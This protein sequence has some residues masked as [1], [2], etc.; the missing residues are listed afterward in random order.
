[1]LRRLYKILSLIILFS[2]SISSVPNWD[3]DEDGVLDNLNDFQNNGSITS[4]VLDASGSN[5]GSPGDLLASFVNGEQRGIAG[6]TQIPFGP[7][8]GQYSFLMLSYSNAASGEIMSFKFYDNELDI[9]YDL[10]ETYEFVSDMTEG[11][12]VSPDVLTVSEA[13]FD[14]CL[15]CDGNDCASVACDDVD[16]DDIC[17]DEDDCVGSYDA[18]GVCN[19]DDSSCA[20][21]AGIPSGMS[22]IDNCGQCV[23][24]GLECV[25][26]C[27]G[28]WGGLALE[29]ECG[30][31][32][33]NGIADG[34]CDCDGNI[35]DDCG[36]C[37]GDGSTC[38]CDL[39]Y[40]LNPL[41]SE[42][43]LSYNQCIPE[44][45]VFYNSTNF[46]GVVFYEVT[47]D[48]ILLESDDWVGAFNN[49]VCVG[50]KKW[51]VNNCGNGICSINL[52]GS[53][54][55][56]LTDGYLEDGEVPTF[57]IFDA[58]TSNYIDAT[59][60]ENIYYSYLMSPVLDSLEGCTFLDECGV[61][62]GLGSIYE[63]GC[64]NIP[65]GECDC[66][67]NILDC[68]NVCGGGAIDLDNDD[69]CDDVDDCLGEYDECGVCNGNGVPDG[70]CDCN[71]NIEDCSGECGGSAVLDE[72]GVCN[73]GGIPSGQCDC[74]GSVIDCLGVC[75]GTAN[76]DCLGVCDGNATVDICGEC[77]GN[78]DS[79]QQLEGHLNQETGWN[80][81]QSTEISFYGFQS[82]LIDESTA[83]GDG[84][85]PSSNT[86]PG[87]STCLDN[88]FTCDVV[89]AFL[90]GVCVGWVYA[91]SDGQTTVP[92]MGLDTSSYAST[93]Q[94]QSYCTTEDTPTFL[95]YSSQDQQTYLLESSVD[96]DLWQSNEFYVYDL[97]FNSDASYGCTNSNAD[98]YN[99][100]A[101][102]DDGTCEFSQT[103]NFNEGWNWVSFNIVPE[104]PALIDILSPIQ[105]NLS[106]AVNESGYA[107]FQNQINNE[108]VDNIGS[109]YPSE[110]YLIK[111]NSSD[112]LEI[113]GFNQILTPYTIDLTSGWNII[114]YPIQ[115]TNGNDVENVLGELLDDEL[116]YTM[117]DENGQVYIPDY[118]TGGSAQNSIG[119]LY[120]GKAY[121]LK[122]VD[123]A[124][125][126]ILEP[127]NIMYS[128]NFSNEVFSY[129]RTNHFIPVW[130]GGTLNPMTILLDVAN[131]D[132]M[133]L[134]QGDEVGI[135]DG[136]VCVG[137]YQVPEGG[138]ANY[139]GIEIS[140]SM[141]DQNEGIDGFVNGN[142]L[143]VRVWRNS[144]QIDIDATIDSFLSIDNE[145]ID[146]V[147]EGLTTPR[148]QI[149]VY[150]PSSIANVITNASIE[151]VSLSWPRPL[152]GDYK[153][154][155]N[156]ESYNSITF[157]IK[158][159]QNIIYTNLEENSFIDSNIDY[160]TFYSYQIVA[161]SSALLPE[162]IS[163]EYVEL[164]RPGT[165]NLSLLASSNSIQ[166]SWD[167]PQNSGDI[168]EIDY[169]LNKS[170]IVESESYSQFFTGISELSFLDNNL[171]NS[172]DYTYR[173]RSFN[174]SGGSNWSD[175]FT[176]QT[177]SFNVE[178]A[179]IDN[180]SYNVSQTIFPP[181]NVV[182]LSW[183]EVEGADY[184]RVYNQN[185]LLEDDII[186]PNFVHDNLENSTLY[187]YSITSVNFNGESEASD[188]I[189][190]M[191]F[192]EIAPGQPQNLIASS[193][194]NAI[195][196]DW[197]ALSGY[198]EPIGGSPAI[199]N[200]YRSPI[201][202]YDIESLES[203]VQVGSTSSNSY[204]DLNLEDNTYFCYSVSGVNSEGLE[205]ELSLVACNITDSQLAVS[206][207]SIDADVSG[208][209]VVI[210]WNEV[211][212]SP[213]IFY[214]VFKQVLDVLGNPVFDELLGVTELL[215]FTDSNL[216]FSSSQNYYVTASNEL[217]IS[218]PSN[219]VY[220]SIE[221]QNSRL[222][223]Y[224]PANLSNNFVD[225]GT[226]FLDGYAQLN[227]SSAQFTQQ[228]A[229]QLFSLSYSNNP[230]SPMAIIIEEAI[231]NGTSIPDGSIIAVFD[232]ELCVGRGVTP[233]P[234]GQIVVSSDDGE[235]NGFT[236]GN[237]V[238]FQV[239]N[240]VSGNIITAYESSFVDGVSTDQE[241]VFSQLGIET[242]SLDVRDDMY[243][244][245]RNG[246]LYA[247]DLTAN[248]FQDSQLES[249]M[250]YF[251]RVSAFNEVQN[252]E[253]NLSFQDN[254]QTISGSAPEFDI[255]FLSFLSIEDNVS[256]Q[257]DQ[258]FEISLD[259]VASD[260]D[261]DL[262]SFFALPTDP[263]YPVS[264][265][266]N[267]NVLS[268]V[269]APN[270][271][272]IFNISLIVFDD[273][274]SN[275]YESNTLSSQ[276]NFDLNVESVNDSPSI[277]N[278]LP[279]L[280]FLDPLTTVTYEIDLS[281]YIVDVD[282]FISNDDFI[283]Y[284]VTISND[285]VVDVEIESNILKID[286]IG[287][288]ET[289]ISILASDQY[290]QYVSDQFLV[291]TEG[292]LSV[293]EI[294]S[295]FKLGNVY[296]NP[297]NPIAYFKVQIPTFTYLNIDI[298]NLL[299]QKVDQIYNGTINS[300]NHIMS[301]EPV[302]MPS[303]MYFLKM[304]ADNFT[305]SN[306]MILL[307]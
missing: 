300:G 31:C 36:V 294:P 100:E 258:V 133:P 253:S 132:N 163:N 293:D 241:I 198:G 195:I 284:E 125:L 118:V 222:S 216:G 2:F 88:P 57:K 117:F 202:A 264:C 104:D 184:Y 12:V 16:E 106:L 200:I 13:S 219:V 257:E 302:G 265:S 92:V 263:S 301:W 17:D 281:E 235:G 210:S 276:I 252:S 89:G 298:Y 11:N 260:V 160:N 185:I 178:L 187:Q 90:N 44:N 14:P 76:L 181:D 305:A 159:D 162:S 182:E 179:K 15:D 278:S 73:G 164:T 68:A 145:S 82:I 271:N 249:G 42:G 151:S 39:G 110:G 60:S 280:N 166:L 58:S 217:G 177:L 183:N 148:M 168:A 152:L 41:W 175:Y 134:E 111:M 218:L 221:N 8:A 139:S 193:S 149:N 186:E 227:W 147:F 287:I 29:D 19:G 170:W 1:M 74:S 306:K 27:A 32:D 214:Q 238:Y 233:L 299:G 237:S 10:V 105:D 83:I 240:S 54:G 129:N 71:G 103:I 236:A 146:T 270:Y 136:D 66:D 204:I 250:D 112:N 126:T 192:P 209:D 80:F 62:A 239:W 206:P 232:N 91:D 246:N 283:T 95:I 37:A 135:F 72:C 84:W 255:S 277:L 48:N 288:G 99:A 173:I 282:S 153:I 64:D 33:G 297:F 245:Y 180:V 130:S 94:T 266:I 161:Q 224:P 70:A 30:V 49:D 194:Q 7:N 199:Y 247:S 191:T 23:L 47:L 158:R 205:G 45:F 268:V 157:Q 143:T 140:T 98:N 269:P 165:P 231:Y 102:I 259:G 251:Y 121:Y 215:S 96:Y 123:D 22:F 286:F 50:A 20:D 113:S 25:Q 120:S 21:C 172:S 97:A 6:A 119:M 78:G 61:C 196:L 212:G 124:Q 53:D 190:L 307:K 150:A 220:T 69:I 285:E 128:N 86:G 154:Y 156:G 262:L 35:L 295:N 56:N 28:T 65:E 201:S 292:A 55:S 9:V 289:E 101:L 38:S 114:S 304:K 107:I 77:N 26:D 171:L 167:N 223:A 93:Q 274:S 87:D 243:N 3:C 279:D 272:G 137:A 242:V 207:P 122:V 4:I 290:G 291:T 59:P 197:D 225:R 188:V 261:G 256:I 248:S 303:G 108:W 189:D 75:G 5:L 116:V 34:A 155:S 85:A 254:L 79:C 296:P 141:D 51:D 52:N 229:E 230:F 275:I 203:L 142:E 228:E 234:G 109:W 18:C 144:N 176:I 226:E 131:W 40:T 273:I 67:G 267:N 208:R 138:F 127:A 213:T 46:G 174:D 43:D 63:C 24:P 169:V 244:L 81:Y 115:S 211:N